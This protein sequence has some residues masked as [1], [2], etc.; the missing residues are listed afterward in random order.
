MVS[1][2]FYSKKQTV[3]E[4][5]NTIEVKFPNIGLTNVTENICSFLHISDSK[6][7]KKIEKASLIAFGKKQGILSFEDACNRLKINTTLPD[8]TNISIKYG[9]QVIA[10]YK[11]TVIIE[12]L[13]DGWEPNWSDSSENKYFP[14]FDLSKGF[15][16]VYVSAF[17]PGHWNPAYSAFGSRLTFKSSDLAR[18]AGLY[19]IDLYLDSMK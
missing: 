15:S 6:E 10:N 5:V 3:K 13:N 19:F 17:V 14:W 9:K 12:A 2:N 1:N 4:W 18:F 7:K 8:V 16:F 11:L